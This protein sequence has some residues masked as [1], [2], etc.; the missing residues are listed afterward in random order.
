MAL[1]AIRSGIG[2]S[3]SYIGMLGF[4]GRSSSIFPDLGPIFALTCAVRWSVMERAIHPKSIPHGSL[5]KSG[6]TLEYWIIPRLRRSS[7]SC[8]KPP[9]TPSTE[10][11]MGIASFN[12]GIPL[13]LQEEGRV[14]SMSHLYMSGT[15]AILD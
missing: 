15:V 6:H 1:V 11:L 9:T 10:K 2:A 3:F 12:S 4:K 5:K 13:N 14:C 8:W 7:S